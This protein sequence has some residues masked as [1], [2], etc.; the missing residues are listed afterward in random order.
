MR[1]SFS[2]PQKIALGCY[3]ICSIILVGLGL[4]Y[5]F[6]PEFMP[7]HS[8]AVGMT[9]QD[10]PSPFKILILALMKACGGGMLSAGVAI[11]ILAAKP[12]RKKERWAIYG[13]PAVGITASAPSIWA[14]LYVAANTPA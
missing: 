3:A 6:R 5:I 8:D 7:Y 12:F 11:A 2:I 10:V 14:T 13:I 9:W 4:M 1:A